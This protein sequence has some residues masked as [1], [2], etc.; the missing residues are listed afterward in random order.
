MSTAQIFATLFALLPACPNED[1]SNC[2]WDA[3]RQSNGQGTSFVSIT[4]D[5]NLEL[6]VYEDGRTQVY[7]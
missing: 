5:N 4:L 1:S 2:A 6:L 3:A 7:E